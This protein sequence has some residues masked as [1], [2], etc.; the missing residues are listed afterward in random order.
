MGTAL[1]GMIDAGRKLARSAQQVAYPGGLDQGLQ[2]PSSAAETPMDAELAS[3]TVG[4]PTE[5]STILLMEAAGLATETVNRMAAQT[6]FRA[7]A[8]VARSVDETAGS[9]LDILV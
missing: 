5:P 3:L 1:S 6:A 8:A 7:N 4:A 2:S 9:T